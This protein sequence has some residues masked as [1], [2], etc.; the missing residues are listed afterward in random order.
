MARRTLL[1]SL[2]TLTMCAGASAPESARAEGPLPDVRGAWAQEQLTTSVSKIPI[3]GEVTSTT[4]ALLLL[5]IEQRGAQLTVHERICDVEITSTASRVRTIVPRAF[6]RAS[7]GVT[8]PA[9]LVRQGG[10]VHLVQPPKLQVLGA[11][12]SKPRHEALPTEPDD[13][14][15]VDGDGDGEPGLTVLVRGVIDGEIYVAQR[16]WNELLGVVEPGRID[17]TVRWATEQVVLGASRMLLDSSPNSHP[18]PSPK[19]HTFRTRALGKG[20]A[21]CAQVRAQA[22]RLFE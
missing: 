18:H 17:G 1:I 22:P 8:R 21:T 9:R 4:R 11:R 12:L 19:R 14:R 2:C 15:V 7:S 13:P 5:Q 6:Q 20:V 3:V 16:G 10:Q